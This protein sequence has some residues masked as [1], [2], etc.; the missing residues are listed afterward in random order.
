MMENRF[1]QLYQ[2]N[3]KI[4]QIAEQFFYKLPNDIS[5]NCRTISLQTA[6]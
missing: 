3:M 6:E 1:V 4:L 5:S 2:K